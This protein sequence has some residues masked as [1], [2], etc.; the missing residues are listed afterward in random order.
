VRRPSA[1]LPIGQALGLE[2]F[3]NFGVYQPNVDNNYRGPDICM[4]RPEHISERG[5]EGK[6]SLVIEI[7]SPE[8]ESYDKMPFYAKCGIGEM[9]II[10]PA[11]RAHEVYVLRGKTYCAIAPAAGVTR[12]PL[13]DV[14]LSLADGP[15]LR[16]RWAS[17]VAEI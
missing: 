12:S 3:Q 16:V 13:L 7:L 1:R 9:W 4:A 10:D 15:K 11:T 5:I 6:A 8:D 2:T 14:E 17:G